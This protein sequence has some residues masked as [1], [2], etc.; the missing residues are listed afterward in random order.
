MQKKN[1]ES[2]KRTN[3]KRFKVPCL[4]TFFLSQLATEWFE[5]TRAADGVFRFHHQAGYYDCHHISPSPTASHPRILT[6]G[7]IPLCIVINST[8]SPAAL[9]GGG[10]GLG[11]LMLSL[12]I[13]TAPNAPHVAKRG[14]CLCCWLPWE[15]SF[16][17][18]FSGMHYAGVFCR[19][20]FTTMDGWTNERKIPLVVGNKFSG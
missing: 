4:I 14:D 1:E 10:G 9:G 3:S 17:I 19:S 6:M 11:R 20:L 12:F 18:S 5:L 15:R 16:L 2:L 8:L 7:G 13:C